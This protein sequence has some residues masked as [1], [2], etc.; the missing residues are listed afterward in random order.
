[1]PNKAYP[2]GSSVMEIGCGVGAQTLNLARNSPDAQITAVDRSA[3]SL[4]QARRQVTAAGLDNVEFVHADLFALPFPAASFDHVFVCFVLEHLPQPVEA[5]M[6][7]P[8][9]TPAD[10]ARVAPSR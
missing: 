3:A 10:G 7:I 1:M 8:F 5:L 6:G 2:A 9:R 4:A